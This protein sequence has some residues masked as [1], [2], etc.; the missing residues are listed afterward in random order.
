MF[1]FNRKDKILLFS[2]FYSHRLLTEKASAV[3]GAVVSVADVEEAVVVLNLVV[4]KVQENLEDHMV[5]AVLWINR[6]LK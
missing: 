3:D 5:M 1:G 6:R 4:Q 2:Q